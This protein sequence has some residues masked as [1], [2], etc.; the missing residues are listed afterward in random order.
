MQTA[1]SVLL[2][3]KSLAFCKQRLATVLSLR[4]RQALVKAL[5]KKTLQTFITDFPQHHLLVVTSDRSIASLADELDV[6]V[7]REPCDR[8]L[9]AAVRAGTQW[10]ME[11]GYDTQVVLAPD[12]AELQAEE[13]QQL[14]D[15][16][17]NDK[18]QSRLV[19]IGQAKDGGTNV[20]ITRPP[21][22]IPFQYGPCSANKMLSDS[23]QR[24][25]DSQAIQLPK[26]ALDIDTPEDLAQWKAQTQEC[27]SRVEISA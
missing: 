13:L 15:P 8:G 22:L 24:G 2:P 16:V 19:S 27:D 9:N 17:I 20:L 25:I 21:N 6:R 1:F 4:E 7:L 5:L 11:Q 18:P 23:R 3:V 10:S 14:F 12:I 26:L